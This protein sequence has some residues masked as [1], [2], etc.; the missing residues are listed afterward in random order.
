[1]KYKLLATLM[2]VLM[3]S[4]PVLGFWH[5]P[6]PP[7]PQIPCTYFGTL[8]NG[9]LTWAFAEPADGYCENFHVTVYIANVTD[10]YGY[11]FIVAWDPAYFNL[12]SWTVAT[13]IWAAQAIIF[14]GTSGN[15]Y[16]QIVTALPPSTGATGDFQLVDLVFHI[17]ND[18]CNPTTASGLFP[19]T[20]TKASN[21]CSGKITLCTSLPATW[22]FKPK[23]PSIWLSPATEVN[24]VVGAQFTES[25]LLK[26][27]VKMT[28]FSIDVLWNMFQHGT[29][30]PCGFA[31]IYS[32]LL[33]TDDKSVV[34]NTALF[35]ATTATITVSSP[36]CGDYSLTNVI[37]D[38]HVDA[39]A[40]DGLI[41]NATNPSTTIWLFN[42]TFTK[43]DAWFCG[44]QPCYTP[45]GDHDWVLENASTPIYFWAGSTISS[46]CGTLDFITQ[47]KVTG[48]V[49]TFVPIPGDLDGSGHVDVADLMIESSYYGDAV[50][51]ATPP[52]GQPPNGYTAFYDLNKDGVIDIYDIVIVAKNFC[53]TTP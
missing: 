36:D 18:V 53:R 42:I 21:S 35:N 44:A 19:L 5:P 48:A 46:L 27:I 41:I 50:N 3:L 47:V 17:Q 22:T 1:M 29:C 40:N 49:F 33:T 14:N 37:G 31:G 43:C 23:Q 39:V 8:I 9:N 26:D 10:L 30:E 6:P 12:V 2:T 7:G 51:C 4:V 20:L 32:A 11:D 45:K 34:L 38:V 15:T 52:A 28:D 16:E 24:S 13:N 25:V